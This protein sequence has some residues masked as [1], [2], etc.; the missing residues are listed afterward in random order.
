LFTEETGEDATLRKIS[1]RQEDRIRLLIVDDIEETRE[2]LRKLLSFDA[3]LE[4][5][6]SAGSGFEAIERV[7]QL[8]PN[9]VLMDINMPG[10]DGITAV[11]K[12]LEVEPTTQVIMLS[13]QGEIDY[14][15][16]AMTAGAW[17]FLTKPASGSELISTIRRV[18]DRGK[19]LR[20]ARRASAIQSL[21]ELQILERL[22]VYGKSVS[23]GY[24]MDE[25]EDI[26]SGIP[27]DLKE[28]LGAARN[29]LDD[30]SEGLSPLIREEDVVYCKNKLDYVL[31]LVNRLVSTTSCGR[32]EVRTPTSLAQAITCAVTLLT[33]NLQSATTVD[34]HID[35]DIAIEVEDSDLQQLVLCLLQNAIEAT[36]EGGTVQVVAESNNTE[37][38]IKVLDV[39]NGIEEPKGLVGTLGY[40]TK[41][42]HAGLGLFVCN[43]IVTQYGGKISILAGKGE[44]QGV[45]ASIILPKKFRQREKQYEEIEDLK[46]ALREYR[47]YPLTSHESET[48]QYVT[49]GVLKGFVANVSSII[50]DVESVIFPALEQLTQRSGVGQ[51]SPLQAMVH[52][53]AAHART[54]VRRSSI[55][56]PVLKQLIPHSS[57]EQ[58]SSLRIVLR[59]C[60]YARAVVRSLLEPPQSVKTKPIHLRTTLVSVLSLFEAKLPAKSVR[61]DVNEKTWVQS[62]LIQFQRVFFNL[63]RNAL[64]AMRLQGKFELSVKAHVEDDFAV[65]H[66]I[67]SGG[68]IPE[69]NL[70]K[71]FDRGFSTKEKGRGMGLFVAKTIVEQ[72][73]GRIEAESE[74]GVGT[75][76]KIHWPLAS[77]PIEQVAD[78]PIS[79]VL[80]G[81]GLFKTDETIDVTASHP[82]AIPKPSEMVRILIVEDDNTWLEFLVR[83]LQSPHYTIHQ[84]RKA[85]EAIELVQKNDYALVLLDWRMPGVGGRGVLE[86][87]QETNPDTSIIILSAFGDAEQRSR[88]LELGA[89]AFIDKPQNKKQWDALKR[90]VHEI[91]ASH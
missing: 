88:A 89:R 46:D 42:G 45:I 21:E 71:I 41:P 60:A 61:I 66:F 33:S 36:P 7:R 2:N 18:Y 23:L 59:N 39:G 70:G 78:S 38:S 5:V 34:I 4:V 58:A 43:R 40:T 74:V 30:L 91:A 86:A 68:G 56:F 65:I 67:D 17:D 24:A 80:T 83:R 15:R 76:F 85:G 31:L 44:E 9:I 14:L 51:M 1:M 53:C 10:M 79:E 90:E 47:D 6:D 26:T 77:Q 84:T 64:E 57:A 8:R 16:R 73:Q 20:L 12:V 49:I 11:E 52:R 37:C 22:N 29:I 75:C 28:P 19:D 82:P 27:H 72:H 13:V 35:S 50:E 55:I 48:V 25:L 32:L 54:I 63:T 62:D 81:Q 87:T 3:D 69:E